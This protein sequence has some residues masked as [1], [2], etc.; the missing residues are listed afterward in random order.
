MSSSWRITKARNIEEREP[1]A[2]A[3]R[4]LKNSARLPA[5]NVALLPKY[6]ISISLSLFL[7]LSSSPS[8][9]FLWLARVRDC[10]R[11]YVEVGTCLTGDCLRAQF[12]HPIP[13]PSSNF[14]SSTIDCLNSIRIHVHCLCIC[15]MIASS[16]HQNQITI[17]PSSTRKT[18][19]RY[20][21]FSRSQN[22]F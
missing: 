15:K 2:R 3:A 8:R 7:L 18:N 19:Y 21:Y 20:Y 12:P 9:I 6:E 22:T 17:Y 13:D 4:N 11:I 5:F 16:V 14:P 1:R 10:V